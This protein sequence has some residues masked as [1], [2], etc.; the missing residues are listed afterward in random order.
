LDFRARHPDGRMGSDP[1]L[2]T[3]ERGEKLVR[4]AVTGLLNE[5]EQ[6]AREPRID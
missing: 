2:A 3:P 5:V 6:F 1:S 4:T